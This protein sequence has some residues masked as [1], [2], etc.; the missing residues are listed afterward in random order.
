MILCFAP[1]KPED[2]HFVPALYF[3]AEQ[4]FEVMDAAASLARAANV[5][6]RIITD[7][8]EQGGICDLNENGVFRAG[9]AA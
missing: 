7:S 8:P 3:D 2:A 1:K 9:P 5:R 6:A 4:R